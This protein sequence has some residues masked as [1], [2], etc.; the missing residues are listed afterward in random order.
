MKK[1]YIT[2]EASAYIISTASHILSGSPLDIAID[3]SETL[4]NGSQALTG[5]EKASANVWGEEW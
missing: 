2:P 4:Y 5:E 1:T 3:D